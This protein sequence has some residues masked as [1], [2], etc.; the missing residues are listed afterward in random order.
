M[1]QQLLIF[2]FVPWFFDFPVGFCYFGVRS[3]NW[4]LL[5]NLLFLK[6]FFAL[7]CCC[8]VRQLKHEGW[9]QTRAYK[10]CWM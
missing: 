8:C 6:T 4:I 1:F 3:G 9:T 5:E 2:T 10:G 7:F